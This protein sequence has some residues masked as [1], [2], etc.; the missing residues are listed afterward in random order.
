MGKIYRKVFDE[1]GDQISG[2]TY[3][4]IRAID[5]N[6]AKIENLEARVSAL[7]ESAAGDSEPEQMPEP[8]PEPEPS[9]GE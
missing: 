3:D 1:I 4:V 2:S 5:R 9:Q 6:L 8:E 7:E